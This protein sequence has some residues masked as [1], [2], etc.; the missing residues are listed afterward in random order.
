MWDYVHTEGM[1][2]RDTLIPLSKL[3]LP[4]S[5]AWIVPLEWLHLY[6]A[7]LYMQLHASIYIYLFLLPDIC[8]FLY[9]YK[10]K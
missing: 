4:Q 5:S 1:R 6:I 9:L 7:H 3:A 8:F 2:Q 10:L